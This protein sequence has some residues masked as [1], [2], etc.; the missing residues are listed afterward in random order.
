MDACGDCGFRNPA[1]RDTCAKCGR[2]LRERCDWRGGVRKA[3]AVTVSIVGLLGALALAIFSIF[4]PSKMELKRMAREER[5]ARAAAAPAEPAPAPAPRA[6]SPTPSPPAPQP[7]EEAFVRPESPTKKQGEEL[8]RKA[9][10]LFAKDDFA[11]AAAAYREAEFFGGMTEEGRRRQ[12]VA[13]AVLEIRKIRD[14]LAKEEVVEP[15]WVTAGQWHLK[16]IDPA[17]LPSDAWREE[18]RRMLAR[19]EQLAEGTGG[20]A[21]PSAQARPER[22][23]EDPAG[24]ERSF[25]LAPGQPVPGGSKIDGAVVVEIIE[26]SLLARAGVKPGDRIVEVNGVRVDSMEVM[27]GLAARVEK[28]RGLWGRLVRRGETLLY[29]AEFGSSR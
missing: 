12:E 10:G 20:L 6:A 21:S 15:S 25:V 16:R 26:G 14:Y 11:G 19:L 9:D 7:P 17:R 5:D 8:L 13:G 18:H 4:G 23:I 29:R 1:G 27:K 24:F 22:M 2:V 28:D 3:V